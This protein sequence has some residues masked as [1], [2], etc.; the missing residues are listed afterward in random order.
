MVYKYRKVIILSSLLI[1]SLISCVEKK[2]DDPVKSY[3]F[4]SG[5]APGKDIQVIHGKY[6]Q[7]ASF[8]KEY[9]VYLEIVANPDWKQ[10]YINQNHLVST[11]EDILFP[12]DAP[13]WFNPQKNFKM[14]KQLSDN[15]SRYFE[16][17]KTGHL[18][19]FEE[20]L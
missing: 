4:W 2:T 6:W 13:L 20:Q 19:I 14:W 10:Q 18:F 12:T 17:L 16:D 15:S 5:E 1:F 3:K 8:S 7:S 9:I 11:N